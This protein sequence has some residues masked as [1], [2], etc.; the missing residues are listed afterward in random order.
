MKSKIFFK[1]KTDTAVHPEAYMLLNVLRCLCCFVYKQ[2]PAR[3][4]EFTAPFLRLSFLC[5]VS[6]PRAARCF[7]RLIHL[8][9]HLCLILVQVRLVPQVEL[10]ALAFPECLF[11]KHLAPCYVLYRHAAY[12]IKYDLVVALTARKSASEDAADVFHS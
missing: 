2:E 10:C 9:G 4:M 1:Y 11:I 5:S 8:T 6:E 3:F 7:A 12:R